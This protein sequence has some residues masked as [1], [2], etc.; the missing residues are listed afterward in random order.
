M[1]RSELRRE[2]EKRNIHMKGGLRK[3]R[4][5]EHFEE[6][7]MPGEKEQMGVNVLNHIQNTHARAP[8]VHSLVP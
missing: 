6:D 2:E 4:S 7:M 1:K 3:G 5:M 8:P